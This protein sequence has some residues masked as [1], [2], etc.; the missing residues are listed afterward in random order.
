MAASSSDER[1]AV[2]GP[3]AVAGDDAEQRRSARPRARRRGA[4]GGRRGRVGRASVRSD[5]SIS[6]DSGSMASRPA[7]KKR[8]AGHDDE[9]RGAVVGG[10]QAEAGRRRPAAR[11][12]GSGRRGS[13]AGRASPRR[14]TRNRPRPGRAEPRPV[15]GRVLGQLAAQHDDGAQVLHG[16]REAEL[17]DEAGAA[18]G[19]LQRHPPQQG[20][21]GGDER[22]RRRAR[23]RGRRSAPAAARGRGCRCVVVG[24]RH[25]PGDVERRPGQDG[26]AEERGQP[27]PAGASPTPPWPSRRTGRR[28]ATGGPGHAAH[29]PGEAALASR[30]QASRPPMAP[31]TAPRKAAKRTCRSAGP[32]RAT[33]RST[34][35]SSV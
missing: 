5:W 29:G 20:Q 18:L 19:R 24:R 11:G 8:E 4:A 33:R 3:T 14:H 22:R 34:G 26:G 6:W 1:G 21:A 7:R 30:R 12:A 32:I 23:R 2:D 16:D 25:V 28:S 35:D 13:A 17:A 27:R 15:A 10:A 31:T 9:R